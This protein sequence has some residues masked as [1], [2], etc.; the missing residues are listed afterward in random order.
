M[1]T[2]LEALHALAR[3]GTMARAAL[4][5]RVTQSAI[6]KRLAALEGETRTKLYERDGRRVRLTAA[7]F[8]LVR[9]TEPLLAQLRDAV[10][11]RE[12]TAAGRIVLGVSES[13]L[14]SWGAPAL[15]AVRDELPQVEVVVRAHRSP[16]AVDHVRSGE[17]ALALVAGPGERVPDLVVEP[18][19]EEEMV[20]VPSRLRATAVRGADALDVLAIEPGS[21]TGRELDR[22]LPALRAAGL[23][24][25]VTGT[26]Q[27][28]AALVQM[29]RSGLGHAVVPIGI[30]RS[31]GVPARSLVRLPAPGLRRRVSLV[32]RK[33]TFVR[34]AAA[35]F[36]Q[37][38]RRAVG[39]LKLE[40]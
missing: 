28:F 27:S 22:G 2:H 23:A 18:L 25:R 39:G 14:A 38:L 8:E 7:G 19:L 34:P 3:H 17:Y 16:V 35:A 1:I 20:V 5:L 37:A 32:G 24:L 4:D 33:T 15:A 31:M 36:R 21:A 6:S 29:A 11:A 12:T 30:A 9:R 40:A 13:I 10:A 26:L